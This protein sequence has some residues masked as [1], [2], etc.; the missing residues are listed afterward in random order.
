MKWWQQMQAELNFIDT[1]INKVSPIL[2]TFLIIFIGWKFLK[3]VWFEF[4]TLKY[5]KRLAQS[6][7]HDIDKMDGLQFE[8]YLKAMLKELGYKS[9]VTTGSHDFGSDLIMKNNNK[10]IVIQAKRYGYKNHV[11]LDAVQQVFAAKTYYKADESAV[12]TNSTFTKSAKELAKSCN[13]K[14]YDRYQLS[15]LI[16]KVNP[17]TKPDHIRKNVPA[18]ERK[19]KSCG[20]TLVQRKSNTGNYFLGCN[21][22]P[23]CKHTESIAK[24]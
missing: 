17:T 12:I 7:M 24:A 18:K 9:K 19:C 10:K 14:T 23:D 11:S 4:K 1:I 3:F 16:N 2:I 15:E 5:Q 21:N 6:G 22:F 13:V 8:A 20:G